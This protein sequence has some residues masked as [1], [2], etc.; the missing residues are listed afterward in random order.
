MDVQVVREEILKHHLVYSIFLCF[1]KHVHNK[2]GHGC[3]HVSES[4]VI[5]HVP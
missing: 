1:Q 3:E 2:M 4:M 5:I